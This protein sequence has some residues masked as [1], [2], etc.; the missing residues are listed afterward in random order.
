MDMD[1]A[2]VAGGAERQ[3][4]GVRDPR[5]AAGHRMVCK[6]RRSEGVRVPGLRADRVGRNQDQVL[7]AVAGVPVPDQKPGV[8][9]GVS[10]RQ[11]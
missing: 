8:I 6:A 11:S 2:T 3:F 7:V 4:Y 5:R 10:L 1:V 9:P